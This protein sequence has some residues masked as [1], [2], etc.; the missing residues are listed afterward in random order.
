MDVLL[1][2]TFSPARGSNSYGSGW[3]RCSHSSYTKSAKEAKLYTNQ[4]SLHFSPVTD[5]K[6]ARSLA[7]LGAY[8]S[9]YNNAYVPHAARSSLQIRGGSHASVTGFHS[10]D[11]TWTETF[12]TPS[13]YATAKGGILS[14][15]IS[16]P[17]LPWIKL[18]NKL[19]LTVWRLAATRRRPPS[20]YSYG[21]RDRSQR[22]CAS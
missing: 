12:R 14:L 19:Q 17:H 1:F 4:T 5:I 9:T 6:L 10:C 2:W 15:R 18:I 3:G 8:H 16:R 11:K 13:E 20:S 22:F 7:A 21:V